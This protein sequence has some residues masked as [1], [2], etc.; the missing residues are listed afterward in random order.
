[1]QLIS[2]IENYVSLQLAV[3]N[4]QCCHNVVAEKY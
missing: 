2:R 1:V 4:T 3:T